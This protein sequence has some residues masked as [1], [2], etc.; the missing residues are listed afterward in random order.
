MAFSANFRGTEA[1]HNTDE[2][3]MA[4]QNAYERIRSTPFRDLYSTFAGGRLEVPELKGPEGGAAVVEVTC[5]ANELQLPVEFGPVLDLDGSGRPD[6]T[7]VSATY[8]LLPMRLRLR[9]ANPE[10]P[11]TRDLYV[12]LGRD[13]DKYELSYRLEDP[14]QDPTVDPAP[15]DPAQPTQPTR[16]TKPVRKK[17]R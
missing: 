6:S 4:L 10:G 13:K 3:R 9:H 2:V 8:R 5:Y 1:M 17:S 15:T 16:P 12:I 14:N 7:D 11:L